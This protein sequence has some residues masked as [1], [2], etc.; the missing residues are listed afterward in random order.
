MERVEE[1]LDWVALQLFGVCKTNKQWTKPFQILPNKKNAL[2]QT[3]TSLEFQLVDDSH[4]KCFLSTQPSIL[5]CQLK[6]PSHPSPPTQCTLSFLSNF[7]TI[8]F[9]ETFLCKKFCFM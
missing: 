6:P 5:C 9:F 2:K 3:S 1:E 4:R 7:Q 8:C